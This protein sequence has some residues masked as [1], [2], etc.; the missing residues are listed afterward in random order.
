MK[1]LTFIKKLALFT[2]DLAFLYISLYLTLIVRYAKMPGS[3]TW[4]DHLMPFSIIFIFWLIIF[5]ISNLYNL[6]YAVTNNTFFQLATRAFILSGLLSFTFFY[7][8]PQVNIAP[9]R[10]LIIFI[11]IYALIFL[12]WRQI[13]NWFLKSSLPK[14]K[15]AI[16]GYNK[17]ALEIAEELNQKPQLGY[18]VSFIAIDD[19]ANKNDNLQFSQ[20]Q[21]PLEV[22]TDENNK[23][24]L[25]EGY[26]NLIKLIKEEK[27]QTIILSTD[28]HQSVELRNLLFKAL[29][30][31]V[32]FVSLP[33]F[34]EDI[35][36]RIPLDAINQMWFLENLSEGNKKYFDIF[37]RVY[38]IFISMSILITS[39][40]FWII[41]ASIIKLESKG[42]VFYLN[43]RTGRNNKDFKLIKFRTMREENN[44]RNMTLENDPRIT[45]FGSLMRKTR[46]DEIPQV[47]NILKGEMSFVGPRPERPTLIKKLELKVPFYNERMLVKPGAT[48]WDQ[49][50]GEYH[51]PS[52]EDTMKK[53]QYDLYYIKN[54]SI[55]L[56]LSIIL[57]T[58]ATILSQGGR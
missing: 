51:S 55:Y 52:Y 24:K 21:L 16:V 25:V 5:Y 53:L 8:N 14:N 15:I 42:P 47:I 33:N 27:I 10:N 45:K 54:R 3:S 11:L 18:I 28:P 17:L 19:S 1:N 43:T 46:I 29:H 9:K 13:I 4:Q 23:I 36:G 58:I 26:D 7:L 12:V 39:I 34:Y 6:R 35:T 20:N 50:S 37:K 56:D 22:S 30:L 48:G 57:K 44:A 49:I 40:P 38:D 2:G 41:F 32:S 31:K